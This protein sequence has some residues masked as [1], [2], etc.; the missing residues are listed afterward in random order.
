MNWWVLGFVMSLLAM[1]AIV[2]LGWETDHAYLGYA[3]S[4]ALVGLTAF[5]AHRSSG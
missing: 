1:P 5:L 2:E 4:A 3:A